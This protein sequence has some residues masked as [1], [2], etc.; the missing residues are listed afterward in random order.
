MTLIVHTKLINKK[1]INCAGL[2]Q[3]E[4]EKRRLLLQNTNY[5]K[6]NVYD[7]NLYYYLFQ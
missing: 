5:F 7:I 1:V 3:L 4:Q 6:I 2:E